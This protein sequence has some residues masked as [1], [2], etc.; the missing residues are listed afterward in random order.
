[1]TANSERKNTTSPTGTFSPTERTS[2]CMTANISAEMS[3]SR[4]PLRMF[5]R[6][7]AGARGAR[8]ERIGSTY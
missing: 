5:M 2:A 1:M 8:V 4:I 3:L 7:G 6:E